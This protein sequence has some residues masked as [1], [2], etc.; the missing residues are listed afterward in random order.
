LTGFKRNLRLERRDRRRVLRLKSLDT[1]EHGCRDG[2]QSTD[3]RTDFLPER[4]PRLGG[5]GRVNGRARARAAGLSG[6]DVAG[7]T[8]EGYVIPRLA[9][10]LHFAREAERIP[11][12]LP[13]SEVCLHMGVAEGEAELTLEAEGR[14]AQIWLDGRRY[15]APV[16]LGEAGITDA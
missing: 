14:M 2:S 8:L 16:T 15:S 7:W 10:G 12:V 13:W 6:L 5:R 1:R 9:S 11:V 4:A 3:C